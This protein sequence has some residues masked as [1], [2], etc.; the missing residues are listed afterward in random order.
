MSDAWNLYAPQVG[1]T[2]L[3]GCTQESLATGT[4]VDSES[5]SGEPYPRHQSVV[6]EDKRA[7]FTTYCIEAALGLCGTLG[8]SIDDLTG[9]LTLFA[10]KRQHGGSRATGANHR[11]Y[12]GAK[13]IMVPRTLRCDHQGHAALEYESIFTSVDGDT[14]P[15]AITDGVGLPPLAIGER[16][17]LGAVSLA[18]VTVASKQSLQIDFGITVEPE[19]G[20]SKLWPTRVSIS[21]VQAT[22]TIPSVDVTLLAAASIPLL[23]KAG[24]HANTSIALLKRS[25]GTLVAGITLTA[26]GWVYCDPAFEASGKEEGTTTVVVKCKYDG[27]NAPIIL[28]A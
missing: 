21:D 13:G 7:R 5:V 27:T 15:I 20:D 25:G 11:K 17:T 19:G 16:F 26:A 24:T 9:G 23:G 3:N 10:Q 28:S 1:T 14:D 4:Q 8:C 12:V 6:S 18:G 22:I 2:V